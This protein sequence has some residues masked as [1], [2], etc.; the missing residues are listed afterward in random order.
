MHE[1]MSHIQR[2]ETLL[3]LRGTS[4]TSSYQR[5]EN[6]RVNENQ[7]EKP[8]RAAQINRKELA[9]VRCYNC[10]SFGHYSGQCLK[11]RRTIGACFSCRQHD[12]QKLE[13]ANAAGK[14]NIPVFATNETTSE[15]DSYA[16]IEKIKAY[17]QTDE[18]YQ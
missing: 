11:P 17:Q 10:S 5:L 3:K 9:S 14:N 4:S 7:R 18:F 1:L 16:D 8:N 12:H 15:R 13:C 2:W 6:T